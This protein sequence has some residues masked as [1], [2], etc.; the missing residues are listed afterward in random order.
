MPFVKEQKNSAY[1]SRYQVKYRR[2]REGKTDYYARKRLV[3]QAKNKYASPKYRL[4]VRITNKDVICQIV[5][6]KLQGDVVLA[7]AYSHELPRYG[8]KHGLTNWAAC[9]ATGLLCARRALTKLGLADKYEG[10]TEPSGELELTEPIEGE[11]RPFKCFL[12]VGVA[13]TSTGARVFGAMKGASDGGVFI[14]H[15]EQRFPGFD[16]ESK[17]LDAETLQRYI[18]GGHVA[19]FMETLEEEDDERFKK[20]FSTY[21]EDDISS[22]DIEDMYREAHE[23]IREDPTYTKTDKA[24]LAAWKEASKKTHPKKLSTAERKE[25]VKAKKEAWLASRDS[26]L[27][28]LLRPSERIV[29]LVDNAHEAVA[30]PSGSSNGNFGPDAG[31][32][33]VALVE[34]RPERPSGEFGDEDSR[35]KE[36]A[37]LVFRTSVAGEVAVTSV[38]PILADLDMQVKQQE[39]SSAGFRITLSTPSLPPSLAHSDSPH[40]LSFT[41]DLLSRSV[42]DFVAAVRE[43]QKQAVQ[44]TSATDS[45]GWLVPYL[46]LASAREDGSAD[47]K[48]PTTRRRMHDVRWDRVGAAYSARAKA[49]DD[50]ALANGSPARSF[51][52]TDTGS[53]YTEGERVAIERWIVDRLRERE[54]EFVKKEE[55]RIWCGTFNVNDKQPKNGG[56]DIQA[57]VDSSGGADLL[58]FGF[59]ELDLSTEAMLRYTPYREEVWRKA[60][61]EALER[62]EGV[63]YARVHSRQ[64]VGALILIYIRS[65]VKDHVGDVTSASLA[66]GL[67]G[68]MANKGAVGVRL[69]RRRWKD[70]PLTFVNSHLA[71]FVPNV[72]QRNAQFRDTAAQLLFPFASYE[73]RDAWTPNL[74]PDAPR[75]LGEGWSVWESDVLVWMGDLNYRLELPREEV[76]RMIAAEQY[77][78]LL[79]FDQLEAQKKHGLAFDDFEESA[80][81]FAPTFK[82]DVGT[83]TYDTSE[84]QRVPSWTDRILYLSTRAAAVRVARYLSHPEVV[85]SDHK[86]VSATLQLSVYEVSTHDRDKVRHEIVSKLHSFAGGTSPEVKLEPGPSVDFERVELDTPTSLEVELVF[87]TWAFAPKDGSSSLTPPWLSVSPTS[88]LILPSSRQRITFTVKVTPDIAGTLSFPTPESPHND[89]SELLVISLRGRDL[90]LAISVKEWVPTVFGA[91]LDCLARLHEPVRTAS[92]EQRRRIG[93][94]AAGSVEDE[95]GIEKSAVP[96]VLHR[97]VSFLGEYALDVPGLFVTSGE[98]ELTRLVRDCLD[99]GDAFPLDK[100]LP[101]CALSQGPETSAIRSDEPEDK[102]HLLD[103]VS[104]LDQLESDIGAISLSSPTL[105]STFASAPPE[106]VSSPSRTSTPADTSSTLADESDSAERYMGL[107]SVADCLLRFLES[108]QEPVVGGEAYERALRCENRDEAYAVVQSL[109]ETHANV[110]LYVVAFLR[111][112]IKQ[113]TTPAEQAARPDRFAIVFSSVLLRPSSKSAGHSAS[114]KPLEPAS[115]P[116]RK[117]QFLAWLLEG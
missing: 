73:E 21:L 96:E 34:H 86:P 59:Q 114:G 51:D 95:D 25:R 77:D 97:L 14:P 54:E 45:H 7:A 39:D 65:D 24:D 79:Q 10:V 22:E 32:L 12:D 8:I 43:A 16:P 50:S 60:I 3:V 69:R 72:A 29:A 102:Q 74:K 42:T 89:L 33:S 116:R 111:I 117:K 98:L 108:L 99:T 18:Y 84:K 104:A 92:I 35:G 4:V 2:R 52:P 15:S 36:R 82:F 94:A 83:D 70:T 27:A 103:A 68:L 112:A 40:S 110:L 61:D 80:I 115:V 44:A 30:E 106:L 62:Q 13:R 23:K 85:L 26:P 75:P 78:L 64:L 28:H 57:W 48:G 56:A 87:A 76:E 66:T 19:E 109:E 6:A 17:E 41:A 100:L 105:P 88:G 46:D 49:T 91:S 53:E 81:S 107:H 5:S 9:Y 101:S 55:I 31:E 93:V 37:L 90:F 67:M 113:A 47:R 58:V 1:F 63:S 20:H 38:L 71:A 11:P